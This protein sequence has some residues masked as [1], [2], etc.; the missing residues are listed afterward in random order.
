M[1]KVKTENKFQ[2]SF[3]SYQETLELPNQ[4]VCSST[5]GLKASIKMSKEKTFL[6][7][8]QNIAIILINF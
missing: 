4:F 6:T 2:S 7:L 8:V 5:N 3:I 1:K